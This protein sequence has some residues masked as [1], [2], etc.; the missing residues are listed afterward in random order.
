[1]RWL[2]GNQIDDSISRE[3]VDRRARRVEALRVRLD[4][5]ALAGVVLELRI[6]KLQIGD[7]ER[8]IFNEIAQRIRGI[9]FLAFLHVD[10]PGSGPSEWC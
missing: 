6:L 3:V 2:R 4:G 5:E 1:M 7:L 8:N 10:F 9:L